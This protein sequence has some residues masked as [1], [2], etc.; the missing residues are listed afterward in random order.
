MPGCFSMKRIQA[1]FCYIL[2]LSLRQRGRILGK[3]A[4]FA[5]RNEFTLVL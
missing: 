3:F 2:G 5:S 1:F 4:I